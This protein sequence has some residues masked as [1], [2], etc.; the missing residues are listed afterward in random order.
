MMFSSSGCGDD[1]GTVSCT[2]TENVGSFGTI[3]ICEE[4][5]ANVRSQLQQA[6]KTSSGGLPADA[7][8]SMVATYAD[9]PCSHVGAIGGC[10]VSQNG[11]TMAIW[12]YQAP[13]G[14]M[15][16][17]DIKTM[18]SSMGTFLSP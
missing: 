2:L 1:G 14:G 18:C 6:C 7:G 13:S 8:V 17:S 4:G 16:A 5:S 10:Q 3:K 12:Y 11:V 15:Q 9:A